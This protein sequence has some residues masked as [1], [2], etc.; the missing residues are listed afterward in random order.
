SRHSAWQDWLNRR[1]RHVCLLLAS[2][3][4]T[5]PAPAPSSAPGSTAWPGSAPSRTPPIPGRP[6]KLYRSRANLAKTNAKPLAQ[7]AR[8]F[9]HTASTASPGSNDQRN[10]WTRV[11]TESASWPGRRATQASPQ[12]AGCVSALISDR[13]TT[14]RWERGLYGDRSGETCL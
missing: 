11:S 2:A 4:S 14:Y 12:Q 8:A 3:V 7:W 10:G 6:P 5:L 9:H 1:P 13:L